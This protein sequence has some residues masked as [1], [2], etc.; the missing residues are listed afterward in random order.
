M[1]TPPPPGP[2][3]Q[4]FSLDSNDRL[5]AALGYVFVIV[6]IVVA[7]LDETKRKPLLK[8]HAVQGIGFG[9]VAFAYSMVAGII[10]VCLT[11][12]TLGILGLV[13]WVLFFVP[14]PVGIYFA[15]L[16]YTKG[17]LVEMPFLTDFMTQ[18]GWLETRK[19]A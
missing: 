19:P 2:P 9:V 4:H 14:L 3:E 7:V 10:Y 17:G 1:T 18:Q 12:V 16:A 15:Y 13:L 8:D 6:A 11:I 5:L